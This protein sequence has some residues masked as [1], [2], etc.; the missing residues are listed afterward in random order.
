VREV[1]GRGPLSGIG[2]RKAYEGRLTV[3]KRHQI[4]IHT[5][6]PGRCWA[7]C[8]TCNRKSKQG[9]VRAAEVWM[10]R[11]QNEAMG[12]VGKRSAK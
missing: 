7:S 3:S 9:S 11:H 5:S 8:S 2:D 1:L 12:V 4:T 6:Q 10:A